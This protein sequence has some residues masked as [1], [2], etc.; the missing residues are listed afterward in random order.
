MWAG[1][2]LSLRKAGFSLQWFLTLWSTG[3][4]HMGLSNMLQKAGSIAVAHGLSCPKARGIIPDQGSSPCPLHWQDSLP[5]SH[6]RSSPSLKFFKG[7]LWLSRAR[8]LC[9][10]GCGQGSIHGQGTKILQAVLCSWKKIKVFKITNTRNLH[11]FPPLSHHPVLF[12]F[13][14]S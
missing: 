4:R 7:I 2:T 5:L 10:Y 6:Q 14:I 8:I 13:I 3:S 11:S 12:F 9:F 1:A